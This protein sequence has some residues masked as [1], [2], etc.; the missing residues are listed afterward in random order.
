MQ[1]SH[2]NNVFTFTAHRARKPNCTAGFPQRHNLGTL[3]QF[4][5]TKNNC[6]QLKMLNSVLPPLSKSPYSKPDCF[7]CS[8]K[9]LAAQEQPS[10]PE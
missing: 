1:G 2:W 9:R 7:S 10:A 6:P 8:R 3:L 4:Q 5:E